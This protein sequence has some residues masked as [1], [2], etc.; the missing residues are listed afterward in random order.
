MVITLKIKD[1][2]I[3]VQSLDIHD[4]TF[5]LLVDKGSY[6]LDTLKEFLND[7][8]Y[9]IQIDVQIEEGEETELASGYGFDTEYYRATT[10][11]EQAGGF[12][13]VFTYEH[14]DPATEIEKINSKVD[15]IAIMTEIDLE[16]I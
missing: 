5:D 16:E 12:H 4:N 2:E 8:P 9:S 1:V 6:T 10:I 13:V 14:E 15:Y 11:E 3:N 7:V